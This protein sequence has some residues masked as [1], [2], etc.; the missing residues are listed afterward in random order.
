MIAHI[1]H[2][3]PIVRA[4][5]FR[6]HVDDDF[7]RDATATH[8]PKFQFDP[9]AMASTPNSSVTADM[10]TFVSQLEQLLQRAPLADST[11]CLYKLFFFF[12]TIHHNSH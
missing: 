9:C 1:H 12:F 2:H 6:L 11:V 4:A 8:H 5:L 7:R 3:H 10:D